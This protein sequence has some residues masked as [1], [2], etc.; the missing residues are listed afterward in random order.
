[1]A[2]VDAILIPR[3]FA[4]VPVDH[5]VA[6]AIVAAKDAG[7]MNGYPDGTFRPNQPVT[8]AELAAVIGKLIT[9]E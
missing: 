8:R 9:R 5:W 6:D 2:D 7:L 3:P 1:M 4:D